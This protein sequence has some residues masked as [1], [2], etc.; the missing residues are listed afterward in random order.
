MLQQEGIEVCARCACRFTVT[1]YTKQL[2]PGKFLCRS[3]GAEEKK[4]RSATKE[5]RQA[6]AAARRERKKQAAALLDRQEYTMPSLQEFCIKTVVKFID[7]V[8][9]LGDIGAMNMERIARILTKNRR[10]TQ[11]TMKLFL[12]P[13]I[14][15]L[16]FW[17]CSS[18]APTDLNLISAYCPRLE[19][20]TLSMCGQLNNES[21]RYLF[22]KLGSL[23]SLRLDGPFLINKD[24]WISFFETIGERLEDFEVRNTH[25]FD[26]EI[27]SNMVLNCPNLKRLCLSRLSGVTDEAAIHILGDLSQLQHFEFSYPSDDK[28]PM[29]D[30]GMLTI[31]NSVGS[32]LETL[33]VDGCT[34]LSDRFIRVGVKP[35]CGKLRHLSMLSLDQLS[36]EAVEHLFTNWDVNSGLEYLSV[37][38]CIGIADLGFKAMIEHNAETLAELDINSLQ[39]VTKESLA[40]LT[41]CIHLTSLNASFVRA[42]D[43]KLVESIVSSCPSLGLITVYGDPNV[44]ADCRVRRGCRLIGRQ[45]DSI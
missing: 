34:N 28:D 18:L 22:E 5:D 2:E 39:L 15:R 9:E 31:L 14:R 4:P 25:R 19:S 40:E 10:L 36:D 45:S 44:T 32:Q 43:N 11:T 29:T 30:D 27:M 37:Q 20:L 1:V 41:R 23:R 17:D 12:N 8:E 33:I 26:S 13:D 7:D 3:C 21:F 35:T 24:T 42:M 6:E 38:R 16:E